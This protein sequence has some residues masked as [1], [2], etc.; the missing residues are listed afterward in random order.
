MATEKEALRAAA[1]HATRLHRLGAHSVG[2]AAGKDF[3]LTGFVV[4]ANVAPG[5][6]GNLPSEVD[7]TIGPARVSVPVVTRKMEPFKPEKL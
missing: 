2:T 5:F 3:G 4:V 1:D 7:C 6:A